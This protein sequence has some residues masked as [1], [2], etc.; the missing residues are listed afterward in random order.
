MSGVV[1]IIGWVGF[2][3]GLVIGLLAIPLGLGGNFIILGCA[4]LLGVVTGF[5]QVGI[6]SL[7]AMAALA[8]IGEVIESVLG[9]FTVRKFGASRWAM[10]GTFVGGIGGAILGSPIMPV[11]GSLIGAFIGAFL[12]AFIAEI[13]YRR[14]V[15][16]SLRAGWGAFVGRILAVLIKFEIGIVMI[17]IV[18]WRIHGGGE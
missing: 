5:E 3:L 13:I 15:Q 11:V 6:W 12:G 9:V 10:L 18:L 4:V 16:S 8:I 1:T 7:A 2:Y 14:H 17:I